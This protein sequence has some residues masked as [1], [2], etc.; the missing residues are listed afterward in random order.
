MEEN[1]N[2]SV[3]DIYSKAVG[4]GAMV[5]LCIDKNEGIE[6]RAACLLFSQLFSLNKAYAE[7]ELHT[8]DSRRLFADEKPVLH[9]H[10]AF[11]AARDE[12]QKAGNRPDQLLP[13]PG[14]AA[15]CDRD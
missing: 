7:E 1:V 12:R 13:I 4:F 14:R 5:R 15:D 9:G 8:N 10:L 2:L 6:E 3:T 11:D